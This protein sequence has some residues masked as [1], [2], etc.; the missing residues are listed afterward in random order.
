MACSWAANGNIGSRS[1]VCI[2]L[3]IELRFHVMYTIKQHKP[4]PE[5]LPIISCTTTLNY[6]NLG[7]CKSCYLLFFSNCFGNS[8]KKRKPRIT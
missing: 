7:D 6:N 1:Y 2:F 3:F 5:R 4:V 8:V